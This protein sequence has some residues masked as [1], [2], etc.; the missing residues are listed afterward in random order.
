[1][2]WIKR[3]AFLTVRRLDFVVFAL[4]HGSIRIGTRGNSRRMT[5]RE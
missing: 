1:V 5:S 3:L 2:R 4:A